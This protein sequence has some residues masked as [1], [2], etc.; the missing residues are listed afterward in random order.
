MA[1][2]FHPSI[3]PKPAPRTGSV[4]IVE[5]SDDLE[6]VYDDIIHVQQSTQKVPPPVAAKPKPK[7]KQL[8]PSV[9]EQ[10]DSPLHRDLTKE[11]TINLPQK[12][13]I[14][15]QLPPDQNK[16]IR[17]QLQNKVT[18]HCPIIWS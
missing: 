2:Q 5:H 18:V 10:K 13:Q 1:L 15:P 17:H 11:V 12:V 8:T 3:P 7:P 14:R 16:I 6:T 4:S 9:A